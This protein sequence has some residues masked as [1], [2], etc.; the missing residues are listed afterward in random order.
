MDLAEIV[1]GL[2]TSHS[3]LLS[4]PDELWGEYAERD[5]RNPFLHRTSDGKHV[6]YEELLETA[7]PQIKKELT[8]DVYKRRHQA[9]QAGIERVAEALYK[10][11]PDVLIMFG[12]DQNEMFS[13]DAMPATAV[14]WSDT[15]P[16]ATRVPKD[17]DEPLKALYDT[18]GGPRRDDYP[19]DAE[20]GL[21]LVESLSE[22]GQDVMHVR[23]FMEGK[24][25]SHAFGFVWRRLMKGR[26]TIPVVPVHINTYFP[27]NQPTPAHCY[28]FGQKVRN[29]IND[30]KKG[31]RVAVLAS[32]GFSHFTVDEEIDRRV[33]K[34]LEDHDAD[35]I[36]NLPLE[37]LQAGTSEIRNW[38]IVSGLVEDKDF[39][40]YD[41][42]PCYRSLAGSGC[43]MT[44]GE[45]S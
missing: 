6:T 40:L 21:H 27:P 3:P 7:D 16:Y 44:F 8:A 39:K 5:R 42:V 33:I 15:V 2:G 38:L 9:N 31:T 24:V 29:A 12:D 4:V 13:K 19:V 14:F 18:Y 43:A 11:D 45:W 35:G 22:Q 28:E 1:L 30:W 37:R 26:K 36:R 41:Y 25:M 10:A 20:L 32:G 23:Q 34:Q 17:E